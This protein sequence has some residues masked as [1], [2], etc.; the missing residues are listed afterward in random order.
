MESATP[1]SVDYFRTGVTFY[2]CHGRTMLIWNVTGGLIDAL[3]SVT[4]TVI[5]RAPVTV[6]EPAAE[7]IV[8]LGVISQ[9]RV[10]VEPPPGG[11][12][13]PQFAGVST[14]PELV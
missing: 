8:G 11:L 5:R 12:A 14:Q 3:F 4:S 9:R 7:E 1:A 13:T 10:K 6:V 2:F